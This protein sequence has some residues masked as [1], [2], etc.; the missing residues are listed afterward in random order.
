VA[1]LVLVDNYEQNLALASAEANAPGLLHVHEDWMRRLE[2]QGLL[3][4]QLEFLPSRKQVADRLEHGQGMTAP[5]LAVLL[6]YT[7]IVLADE[8]IDTDLPDDPFLRSD[9]FGYFPAKMRQHYRQQMEVHPLRR[10]II[11]TQI[12]NN[13]VNGAGSTYFHRLSGETGAAPAEIARANFIA[14]EIYGSEAL[15]EEISSYDNKI[16]AAAQTRMRLEVRTLVERASRWLIANRRA[17]MDSEAV[18]DFFEVVVQRVMAALPDLLSGRELA[19]FEARRE[20]L[21]QADVPED[22]AR[23]I[24][25]L[26]PAYVLLGVVDTAH[27]DGLDPLEVTKVHF[28]LGERLGIPALATRILALPRRDRWQTM[29]R[30]ALRDDLHSVHAQ[31]TGQVL[32]RTPADRD[33]GDRVTEWE[34]LEGA[35]VPKAVSTLDEI[36]TDDHADLA[37]LSVG[38]RVVRA[39][40]ATP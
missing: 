6:A 19:T 10:E 5:E 26:P 33:A 35:T 27:R 39:L 9:L 15:L 20:E 2:K 31:L 8:L 3:N 30:A 13:L 21:L 14:R 34:A 25:V 23:R 40:L 38:L 7:K 17:P 32:G 11:V 1:E 22:L 16:D 12:V 37:R 29:A 24:A 18:V 28:E 4:R 36:C